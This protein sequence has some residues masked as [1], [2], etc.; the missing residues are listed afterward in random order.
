MGMI[1]QEDMEIISQCCH[2]IKFVFVFLIDKLLELAIIVEE[3][4]TKYLH[5]Y[6]D[7]FVLAHIGLDKNTLYKKRLTTNIPIAKEATI[8]GSLLNGE[9]VNV[10]ITE[11]WNGKLRNS[12]L[13][14]GESFKITIHEMLTEH[15]VDMME[16]EKIGD[17]HTM[18]DIELRITQH[19]DNSEFH[20]FDNPKTI[21]FVTYFRRTKNK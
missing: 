20:L 1:N 15:Y 10:D 2:N 7:E 19:S 16:I 3:G 6:V 12:L 18:T 5:P 4:Y 21:D 17:V 9:E 14:Y 8:K 13:K 11:Y